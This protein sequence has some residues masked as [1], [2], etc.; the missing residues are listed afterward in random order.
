MNQEL[1]EVFQLYSIGSH[2]KLHN[3]LLGKSKDALI[4]TLVDLI[5]IYI[6][7]KNSSTV[8][9]VITTTLA[10]YKH[11]GKKIG[12]NGFKQDIQIGSKVITCEA[13]S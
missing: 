12:Y 7:D 5:T 11:A 9:E 13:M 10:G 2:K 8:R 3:Y 1:V 6:N 4:G